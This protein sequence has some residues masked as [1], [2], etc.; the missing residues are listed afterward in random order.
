VVALLARLTFS[1]QLPATMP[2]VAAPLITGLP[3]SLVQLLALA[4]L[5]IAPLVP[6][7][8]MA[9][10]PRAVVPAF[11][12]EPAKLLKHTIRVANLALLSNRVASAR[13][14]R[15]LWIAFLESGLPGAPALNPVL[16]ELRPEVLVSLYL[17]CTAARRALLP[18]RPEAATPRLALS[19]ASLLPSLPGAP[20]RNLAVLVSEVVPALC[21]LLL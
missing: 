12:L 19:I 18:L 14:T 15:A 21:C 20:A 17:R 11:R 6:M 10:A 13:K 1:K 5:S 9:P 16:V 4:T 2:A 8:S 7:A 3:R